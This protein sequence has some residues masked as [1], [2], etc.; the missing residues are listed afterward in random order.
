MV[1]EFW[2]RKLHVHAGSDNAVGLYEELI[3]LLEAG[4]LSL[5]CSGKSDAFPQSS[6]PG[7]AGAVGWPTY[8]RFQAT[9]TQGTAF[10]RHYL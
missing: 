4:W 6:S 2:E 9:A 5:L 10:L 3:C 1:R 7:S 8:G